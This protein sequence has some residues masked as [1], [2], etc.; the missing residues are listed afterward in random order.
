MANIFST[1]NLHME[2]RNKESS[3]KKVWILLG[4]SWKKVYLCSRESTGI[5]IYP[6]KIQSYEKKNNRRTAEVETIPTQ[7]TTHFVRSQT[8]GEDIYPEG[9]RA[10]GI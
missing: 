1:K 8:S 4:S 6:S 3:W 7:K 2:R 10:Q 9:I 5:P